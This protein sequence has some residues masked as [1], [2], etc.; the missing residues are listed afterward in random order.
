M[1]AT[2]LAVIALVSGL[3]MIWQWIAAWRFPLNARQTPPAAAPSVSVLKPVKGIDPETLAALESWL[4]QAYPG[5]WEILFGVEAAED[6][7]TAP[8]RQLLAR[9]PHAPARLL[10]CNERLGANRKVSTLIQL[11]RGARG[12]YLVVS[13]ADVAAPAAALTQLLAPFRDPA[14]GLTH[15][16]YRVARGQHPA[17]RW[18][19]FVVNAD[20]WSQVLQHQTLGPLRYALGAAMALRRT[21]LDAVGG[22]ATIADQLADDHVLG[23]RITALGRRTQLCGMVVDSHLESRG[24]RAAW[25]H[26]LRWAVTIRVCKP[27]P[28]FFS[29]LAN[30][31]LWP[32]LAGILAPSRPMA[33]L[34]GT[35]V[36]IRLVQ[37]LS[38]EA[39]FTGRPVDQA[40]W[41]LPWLKDLLQA[42]LW[43]AALVHPWVVWRGHR[44]RVL[45]SGRLVPVSP[46]PT[47][48]A[49]PATSR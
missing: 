15:C 24:W 48:P 43:A 33:I 19:S 21:D 11:A 45:R 36:L 9:H 35:L 8:L 22:F 32:L 7:A 26:Q 23:R 39:R 46:P 4:I 37:G 10:I 20:F 40:R 14:I 13:D 27:V 2:L 31:T 49:P 38:L 1:L 30:G 29:I 42:G 47:P 34:A 28:H 18:E 17:A 3:L 25:G 12:E 41:W 6:A 44:F 5:P 16:L